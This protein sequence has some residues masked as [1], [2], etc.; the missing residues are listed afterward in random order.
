MSSSWELAE[1]AEP[2]AHAWL[3][4]VPVPLSTRFAFRRRH[5]HFVASVDACT[6]GP[7]II[8]PGDGYWAVAGVRGG[9]E[10]QVSNE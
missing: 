5:P 4:C 3:P 10:M 6:P 1:L 2:A 9:T 7:G 8:A